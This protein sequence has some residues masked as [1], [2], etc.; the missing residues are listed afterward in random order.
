MKKV[1]SLFAI[2]AMLIVVVATA[3]SPS[4][5]QIPPIIIDP[6]NPGGGTGGNTDN[7]FTDEETQENAPSY[8]AALD[9][10][11]ILSEAAGSKSGID[12][13]Q[14]NGNSFIVS[15]NNFDLDGYTIK[16]GSLEFTFSTMTRSI[17][18]DSYTVTSVENDPLVMVKDGETA[19]HELVITKA[20]GSCSISAA[21]S[22]LTITSVSAPSSIS[23]S[24]DDNEIKTDY[25]IANDGSSLAA[26]VAK[27][28]NILISGNV[29]ITDILNIAVDGTTITGTGNASITITSATKAN[30]ST[31]LINVNADSVTI[32]DLAITYSGTALNYRTHILKASYSSDGNSLTDF[33]LSNVSLDPKG[34]A[35]GLNLHGVTAI[36]DNVTVANGLNVALAITDS[37]V[38]INGGDYDNGDLTLGAG[39]YQFADIQINLSTATG[40]SYAGEPSTVTFTDLPE[41]VVVYATTTIGETTAAH[42][43]NGIGEPT[44]FLSLDQKETGDYYQIPEDWIFPSTLISYITSFGHDRIMD[45]LT[46]LIKDGSQFNS[47]RDGLITLTNRESMA[48]TDGTTL[49]LEFNTENYDWDGK[50]GNISYN[51]EVSGDFTLTLTGTTDSNTFKATGYEFDGTGLEITN[52]GNMP[53]MTVSLTDVKGTFVSAK[54]GNDPKPLNITL[55]GTT[56]ADTDWENETGKKTYFSL[57]SEGTISA[58]GTDYSVEY[59]GAVMGNN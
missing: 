44:S 43:I 19:N 49:V 37:T 15:F 16:D 47:E 27:G 10:S 46:R 54:L 23:A 13:T 35:A 29:E 11:S 42:T 14:L 31:G 59:L 6:S 2:M 40:T 12:N 24:I 45:D 9:F 32:K 22:T 7:S 8:L 56:P 5:S 20:T 48:V 39:D 53:P 4:G 30:Y 41:D 25:T 52:E 38:S 28:G 18:Y 58:N 34:N 51:R 50:A 55:N 3:C 33:H 57:P 17:S 1:K 36:L 26:A 21:D